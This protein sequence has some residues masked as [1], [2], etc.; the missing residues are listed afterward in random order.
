M[1]LCILLVGHG[2]MRIP[3]TG[4]GAVESLIWDYYCFLVRAGHAVSILNTRDANTIVSVV[5]NQEWDVIHLHNDILVNIIPHFNTNAKIIVS[6]HYPYIQ[7][8]SRWNDPQSGYDYGALVFEPLRRALKNKNVRM[9]VVSPKDY[10]V[11][12]RAFSAQSVFLMLNGVSDD[13]YSFT[14]GPS[15]GDKTL[16]LAQIMKRKRQH[17][18]RDISSVVFVGKVI[19]QDELVRERY[20]GE[21]DNEYKH[22]NMTEYGNAVLLSD[23]E[24]GTPLS[25]KEALVAGL[26]V[27]VSEA[28]AWELQGL[29]WPWVSVI[30][31]SRIQDVEY[32]QTQIEMN[33]IIS[34]CMRKQIRDSAVALWSWS[35]LIPKYLE[36]V[37]S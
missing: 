4:W 26:G 10:D 32:I 25:I 24:N 21:W 23:G 7:D 3:P 31:E 12:S 36:N 34:Q 20:L 8:S 1:P 11:C 15:Q 5:N 29:G 16:C 6:S 9:G 22:K 33:R 14:E 30:Q 35:V 2:N 13:K 17:L 19:D 28:A 37:N 27:V 18:L